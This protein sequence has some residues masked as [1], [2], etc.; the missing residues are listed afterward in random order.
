MGSFPYNILPFSSC[1]CFF[2]FPVRMLEENVKKKREKMT[3]LPSANLFFM[4][5]REGRRWDDILKRDAIP[6]VDI[7]IG[8]LFD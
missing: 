1:Q 8:Y 7:G 3:L 6:N 2:S 5:L 4:Q